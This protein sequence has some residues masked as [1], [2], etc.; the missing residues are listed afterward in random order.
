MFNEPFNWDDPD[1]LVEKKMS[2]IT[3][4]RIMAGLVGSL[5]TI[6]AGFILFSLI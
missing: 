5:I 1:Y 2:D 6:I 4:E 3:N